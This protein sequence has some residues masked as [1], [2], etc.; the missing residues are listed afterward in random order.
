MSDPTRPRDGP[1]NGLGPAE[2]VLVPGA[3][4]PGAGK[5]AATHR[6][7]LALR[8]G[9]PAFLLGL[10]VLLVGLGFRYEITLESLVDMRHRFHDVL[11]HHR[12][13]A[14]LAFV[15]AYIL[16]GAFCLPGSPLLT[17]MGG[18]MFGWLAGG[19]AT[20]VGATI[21]ATI[22]FLVARTALGP[23]L[24]QRAGPWLTKLRAG[25]GRDALSY[26]LFVR[27]VPA[28]PFWFVN[29]AAA[30]L[31][32]S[33]R[34]FVIGTFFGIIPATFTFA[35]AGAGLDRA[36]VVHADCVAAKGAGNCTLTLLTWEL[37]VALV[38][39]GLLALLP[40][41]IKRWRGLH[42]KAE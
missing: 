30:I 32:V 37:M 25:F 24:T 8:L 14:L 12:A 2:A 42:A 19:I 7:R 29:V 36:L 23:T 1:D 5:D 16:V 39:L 34:T 40:V 22:L 38:L 6:R 20:I 17:A 11:D 10:L 27:L 4:G 9:P 15:A 13:L 18:L 41:A 3:G 28:F 35:I 26:L 31:G 33:L 21:G